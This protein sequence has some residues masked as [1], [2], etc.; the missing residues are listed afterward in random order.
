MAYGLWTNGQ[1]TTHRPQGINVSP[2]ETLATAQFINCRASFRQLVQS[3][4]ASMRLFGDHGA[5]VLRCNYDSLLSNRETFVV[6]TNIE[7]EWI[8]GGNAAQTTSPNV[9]HAECRVDCQKRR[10]EKSAKGRRVGQNIRPDDIFY[11][12]R[13]PV[14]VGNM[15]VGKKKSGPLPRYVARP[16]TV[17]PRSSPPFA[18]LWN[19]FARSSKRGFANRVPSNRIS[20]SLLSAAAI[21]SVFFLA[22]ISALACCTADAS[23]F[24]AT[25][26]SRSSALT[27]PSSLRRRVRSRVSSS[28]NLRF[29]ARASDSV[30]SCLVCSSP[31]R[32]SIS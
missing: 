28:S 22:A 15:I 5:I 17:P 2:V 16:R 26:T 25:S 13:A 21:A 12:V 7:W 18:A 6:S 3:F 27:L 10:L 20:I 31:R 1:P 32:D 23:I 24:F 30:A 14:L 19:K 11:R 29:A 8:Y 4:N 9:K